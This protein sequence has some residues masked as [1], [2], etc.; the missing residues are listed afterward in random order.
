MTEFYVY[1]YLDPRNGE[2]FYVGKGCGD[3][4]SHHVRWKTR[5]A[6]MWARIADLRAA[7]VTPI[8]STAVCLNEAD[9][10]LR[11]R[12]LIA[13]FGRRDQGTGTLLNKTSG[14]QGPSGRRHS[15]A[16][17][18]KMSR[19]R[20]GKKLTAEHR[21]NL[22]KSLLL[23]PPRSEEVCRK[24]SAALSGRKFTPEHRAAISAAKKGAYRSP[25]VSAR[26]AASL[27]ATW[28][29]RKAEAKGLA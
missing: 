16:A 23:R 15:D 9:A 4:A 3:R 25:E 20:T 19:S 18:A 6:E 2:V 26:Q 21:A 7:G 22:V 12:E 24:L 28:A 17:K 10:F 27:K 13:A 29:R 5:S 8:I 1:L 14:G 11:E